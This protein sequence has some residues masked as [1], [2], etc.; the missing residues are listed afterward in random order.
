VLHQV[1]GIANLLVPIGTLKIKSLLFSFGDPTVLGKYGFRK[2]GDERPQ[3]VHEPCGRW[4]TNHN[5]PH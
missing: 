4:L 3:E 5:Q 1:K 2:I